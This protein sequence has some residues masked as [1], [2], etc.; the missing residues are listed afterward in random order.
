M[1]D[2][3]A[4]RHNKKRSG[5][6]ARPLGIK[7][8]RNLR[9]SMEIPIHRT[10]PVRFYPGEVS[11]KYERKYFSRSNE[12]EYYRNGQNL[13]EFESGAGVHADESNK[14]T[15]TGITD[16]NKNRQGEACARTHARA[17]DRAVAELF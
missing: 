14:V 7:G 17:Y 9:E 4:G 16:M 11:A 6:Y 1:E 12:T 8:A 5:V 10:N 13:M 2:A 3:F 15:D